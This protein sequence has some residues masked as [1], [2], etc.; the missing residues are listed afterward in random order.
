[1]SIV[2]FFAEWVVPALLLIGILYSVLRNFKNETKPEKGLSMDAGEFLRS[3]YGKFFFL[4][5]LVICAVSWILMYFNIFPGSSVLVLISALS[6]ILLIVFFCLRFE[7]GV[8]IFME[9][10][11]VGII[12]YLFLSLFTAFKNGVLRVDA[13]V[14]VGLSLI[15]CIPLFGP[16]ALRFF[17]RIFFRK[18][19]SFRVYFV[20]N[21]VVMGLI[22]MFTMIGS[23][24]VHNFF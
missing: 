1:M 8:S 6:F 5:L 17:D 10:I 4:G 20:A 3:S 14:E 23:I 19:E 22:W 24:V 2:Y 15:F 9:V 21:F 7:V 18:T 13:D 11:S 16:F 12:G